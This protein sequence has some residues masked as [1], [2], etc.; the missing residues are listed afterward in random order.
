M[1][2]RNKISVV[3]ASSEFQRFDE[4]C[5]NRGYKKSTLIARLIREHLDKEGFESRGGSGTGQAIS[6]QPGQADQP[7]KRITRRIVR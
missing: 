5:A 4:Y 1:T 6:S 7:R 2:V 3:L